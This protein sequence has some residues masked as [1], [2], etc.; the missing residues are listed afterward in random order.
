[1]KFLIAALAVP[2]LL[3]F[4]Q[5][6]EAQLVPRATVKGR[7]VDDSTRSP[8]PLANIFISNSTIGTGSNA[9]GNFELKGIPLGTQQIVASIVGYQPGI[10]TLYLTDSVAQTVE[11]RLKGRPIQMP[12][13]EVEAR[14]PV[15]WRNNLER[16]VKAFF[17]STPNS[18]RCKL[19]NPQ[20]LDFGRKTE[21]FVA[22]ARE[23]I[24][25]E[26]WALGY[27]IRCVLIHFSESRESFQ[28][29]G[30]TA[31]QALEP[32]DET[33]AARWIAN[34]RNAYYG[35]KRHF[36]GSLVRKQTKQEGFELSSV[37]RTRIQRALERPAG[38]EVFA[39]TL[40]SPSEYPFR[41]KFVFPDLLQVVYTGNG[42]QQISLIELNR[43]S[44]IVYPNGLTHDPLGL[45][46]YGYWSSQ[47]V[48]EMLP[49]DF[50]PE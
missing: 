5:T 19:L 27:R 4:Q 11:I 22:T 47:R 14:Q 32:A 34:R 8:L 23:P 31:F 45:W 18:S 10:V 33:E 43:F 48:A 38:F 9:D 24:E 41:T 12:G 36:L 21:P 7:V 35:S 39:D 37:Q 44:V 16:F 50:E 29:M 25:I 6:L 20:V 30:L 3:S 17:G 42:V 13:V 15:E 28:F 2:A 1:M 26:N 40:F 46:T 49:I